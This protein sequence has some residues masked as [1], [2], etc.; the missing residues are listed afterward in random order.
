MTVIIAPS[1]EKNVFLGGPPAPRDAFGFGEPA[2]ANPHLMGRLRRTGARPRQVLEAIDARGK[3]GSSPGR[4]APN[5]GALILHERI[6]SHDWEARMRSSRKKARFGALCAAC[7]LL[8]LFI[9]AAT[10]QASSHRLAASTTVKVGI[11]LDPPWTIRTPSGKLVSFNPALLAKLSKY[12]GVKVQIVQTGWTGIVAGLQTGKYDMI[13]ADLNAT[14]ERRKVIDF[15]VP[16]SYSG[17]TWFVKDDSP[18]KTLASLNNPNVTISFVGGS[19]TESATRTRLPKA[20][21][22]SLPNATAGDLIAELEAGRG[23]AFAQSNYL[24]AALIKKYHYRAI[25]DLKKLPNG[26]GPVGIAWA[27]GKGNSELLGKLNAFLKHE[28]ATGDMAK[29]KKQY[30]TPAGFAA[31]VG[32]H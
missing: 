31:S 7:A 3:T 12:L 24:G 18:F 10:G 2:F 26:I 30:L 32:L 29:L 13:G 21:Y 4:H 16:Y 9:V 15:T 17:T 19:D 22:R 8:G 28:I 25:P 23:D 14:P 20:K 1:S 6:R 27:V 5:H 11:A